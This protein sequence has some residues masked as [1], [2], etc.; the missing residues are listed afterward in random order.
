MG[1][2][3]RFERRLEGLVSGAFAKAFKADV[4]PVE[5]ASALQRELDDRAAIVGKNNTLVPNHFVVELSRHDYDRLSV[6]ARTLSEELAEV[7]RDHS[8]EQNY[9][10]RGEVQVIFEEDLDLDIGVHRVRSSV[11]ASVKAVPP[12][13]SQPRPAGP[14]VPTRAPAPAAVPRP[15]HHAAKTEKIALARAVVPY[16]E[17]NGE[18]HP[19]TRPVTVLGRGT[20]VDLRVD[21]AGVSRRHAEIQLGDAPMLVDLGST[22]GTLLNGDPVGRA[23]LVDGARIGLGDTVL[24]FRLPAG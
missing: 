24:V 2:L 16:L 23:E 13:Q 9:Q 21:D 17:V 22:N 6:Y 3:Q 18:R 11:V 8:A 7:V 4:Q 1:V 10:L 20:Q 14:A 15:V 19:L 12:L 5:I